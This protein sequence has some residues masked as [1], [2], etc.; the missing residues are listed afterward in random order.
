MMNLP[1]LSRSIL[2]NENKPEYEGRQL[3]QP[4]W[5]CFCCHDSGIVNPHLAALI[6]P[7]YNPDQDKIPLC[8]NSGCNAGDHFLNNEEVERSL[9]MRFTQT[10]CKQLDALH[11]EDWKETTKQQFEQVVNIQEIARSRSLR[12]RDRTPEENQLARQKHQEVST[13]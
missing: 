8:Q 10:I 9:D 11:R 12:K 3:W 2:R 13:R 7:G 1:K 6:V 4:K 5:K